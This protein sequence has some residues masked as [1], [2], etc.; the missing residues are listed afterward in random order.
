MARPIFNRELAARVLALAEQ[1]GDIE[2]AKHFGVS[3]KSV[4]R[5]RAR[6]VQDAELSRLVAERKHELEANSKGWAEDASSF[7]SEAI[8][9][10]RQ[11]L[12]TAG[13]REVVGAIKIIGELDITRKVLSDDE[14]LGGA[15]EGPAAEAPP[16]KEPSVASPDIH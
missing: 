11:L 15:G 3:T 13:M 12:P 1:V 16:G 6:V 10:L 8:R 9:R 7:M 2:A 5:Y 4:T 14:Q